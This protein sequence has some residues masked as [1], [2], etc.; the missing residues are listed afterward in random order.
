V[1][2]HRSTSVSRI[3]LRST[4]KGRAPIWNQTSI[5]HVRSCRWRSATA[6]DHEQASVDVGRRMER[7]PRHSPADCGAIHLLPAPGG[8]RVRACPP[9]SGVVLHHQIGTHQTTAWMHEARQQRA[10]HG[11]RRVGNH[12]ERAAWQPQVVRIG[13]HHAHLR[14]EPGAQMRQPLGMQFD[15]DDVGTGRDQLGGQRS[16]A[17][18]DVEDE[19]TASDVRLDHDA[20]SPMWVERVP[21]PLVPWRGHE[22]APSS[23]LP[24]RQSDRLTSAHP[25]H[26]PH[27][28]RT[29]VAE[30]L[31]SDKFGGQR[32]RTASRAR[33]SR[34]S[35][36]LDCF[37]QSRWSHSVAL[38]S[39]PAYN[40]W[41]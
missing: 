31:G 39:S 23:S 22:H 25:H 5:P 2:S 33:S 37:S 30:R 19:I 21:A 8:R 16:H 27:L 29:D 35:R 1:R 18:T 38:T 15:G 9:S 11:E 3:S 20:A 32:R 28:R 34:W 40:N 26:F 14:A 17:G 7:V 24:C 12:P 41:P 36:A 10:G 13:A 4:T 6:F